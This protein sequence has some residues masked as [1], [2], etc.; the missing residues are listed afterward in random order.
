LRCAR[1]A[2]SS[3]ETRCSKFG[4]SIKVIAISLS[5]TRAAAALCGVGPDSETGILFALHN[6]ST[7][8][9]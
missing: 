5:A 1:K 9:I 3:R 6:R 7:A 2:L 8:L 4:W